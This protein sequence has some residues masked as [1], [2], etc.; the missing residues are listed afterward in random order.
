MTGTTP[1]AVV[2][3]L[4]LL[5]GCSGLQAGETTPTVT[6]TDTATATPTATETPEP[7]IATLENLTVDPVDVDNVTYEYCQV[8]Y[9]VSKDEG[10]ILEHRYRYESVM[11]NSRP[12]RAETTVEDWELIPTRMIGENETSRPFILNAYETPGSDADGSSVQLASVEVTR[13]CEVAKT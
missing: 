11:M 2:A 3:L 10:V 8:N 5:A 13:D 1:K 7:Q 6:D 9:A 12:D 4:V